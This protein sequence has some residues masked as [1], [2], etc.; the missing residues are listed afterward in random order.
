MDVPTKHQE[1]QIFHMTGRRAGEGFAAV[2]IAALR[3]AMLAPYRELNRLRHDY[4]LVLIDEPGGE[5]FALSL[6]T[7]VNQLLQ[8]LAPRGIEGERLRKHMLSLEREI[9]TRVANGAKG[10]LAD[11]WSAAAKR[12]GPGGDE[13]SVADMLTHAT[14]SPGDAAQDVRG[15]LAGCDEDLPAKLLRQA[16]LHAQLE[17]SREFRARVHALMR[18]LSDIKRAAWV[19]SQAGQQPQALQAA[20]GSGHRD[21]FDFDAMSRLVAR[22][23][24]VDE[25]PAARRERIEWALGVLVRQTFYPPAGAGGSEALTASYA[26]DQCAAA[27]ETFRNRLPAVAELIKAIALAELEVV[28]HYVEAEHDAVF[29]RYDAHSLTADDLAV[30]PDYLVCIPAARNEAPENAPLLDMLSSGMPVKVLVQVSDLLEEASI[31][32]GHFAFGVRSARLATTAMGLG[33]MFVMQSAS[34]ALYALRARVARG[35]ACRGPSLFTIYAGSPFP[36]AGLPRYL[37]AAVAAESRAFPTFTY[38]A[39]AGANWAERFSLEN[40]RNA[41]AD[42][43]LEPF[44]YANETLQRVIEKAAFTYADFALCD[45][46]H[47][48]HFAVVPRER[49]HD[50]MLP[51]ADW[52]ALPEGQAASRIPYLLAVDNEDRLHRVIVDAAMMQATRRC[53]LLWHRLQEHAGIHDSHTERALA[54]E[55]AERAA[56]PAAEAPAAA[57][58]APV[59]G[60][61]APAAPEPA[62]A[63]DKPP[64]DEAWIETS[65]CPSCNECQLINDRMFGYNDNKQAYI[66]DINAGTYA[67][68]V[69]AA[70]ACQV[71]IIHPG[72]PRNPKEPG[73]EAL[74]ERA[75][76]FM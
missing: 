71:A 20:V 10:S 31:G 57:A 33:G 22:R 15:L 1:H 43:A 32:T 8:K 44:E 19:H 24:P 40:N 64:S 13:M 70:E 34:S 75:K 52:L 30:M 50:G 36:A 35:M 65:R 49:W 29:E 61:A 18:K 48:A 74:I 67:Q 59:K 41:D 56:Q 66:K 45:S 5:G 38:D 11:L 16:W 60:A 73:L 63:E 25:L 4:P 53:L 47:A 21:V 37:T 9:R 39:A 76:P 14:A 58:A 69:E 51:V 55:R 54:R 68:M 46:R 7:V 3:P 6:S 62:P 12:L 42:W 17:K 2:D 72:K 26:F 28:G 23:A 27:M